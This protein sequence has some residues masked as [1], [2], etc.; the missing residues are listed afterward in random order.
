LVATIGLV[1]LQEEQRSPAK[2]GPPTG[3]G[4]LADCC[5]RNR[6][7]LRGQGH[8]ESL[9]G[10]SG[11][12]RGH[13]TMSIGAKH[14]KQ[15]TKKAN[16]ISTPDRLWEAAEPR[17]IGKRAGFPFQTF[18]FSSSISLENLTHASAQEVVP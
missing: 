7:G 10:S 15:K 11:N 14:S 13:I 2:S 9:A 6:V 8:L 1:W 18:F 3:C 5:G 4:G 17:P 12:A 16:K